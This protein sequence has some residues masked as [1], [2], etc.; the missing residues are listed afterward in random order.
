MF[1]KIKI[2]FE[3]SQIYSLDPNHHGPDMY[4][5]GTAEMSLAGL[6]SNSIHSVKKLPLK[7]AAVS[8]CYRAET[9]NVIEERGTYR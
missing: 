9:S 7:L 3:L 5:S 2:A 1:I 6:L 4:L 8:R